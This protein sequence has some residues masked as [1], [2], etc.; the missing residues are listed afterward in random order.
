MKTIAFI[1]LIT[2]STTAY[3]AEMLTVKELQ[4]IVLKKNPKIM[5]MELEAAMLKQRIPQSTAIEDPKLKIGLNN[6]P[7]NNFS[8]KAEDMTSKEIGISQMFPLGGKLAVKE[9]IAQKEYI[10]SL[11]KIKKEKLEIF[12]ML[13]MNIY[14]LFYVR[15]SIK[16]VEEIK[17]QLQ[18]L[19]QSEVVSNKSGMG[20]LANVVK[21]NIEYT[22]I[23]EE[24]ISLKQQEKEILN[25][26]SYLAGREI[27]ITEVAISELDF[28]EFSIGDVKEKIENNNPNINILKIDEEING[29]EVILKQKEYYP[30]IEV[31]ISYMQ[32]DNGAMGSRPDMVSAMAQINIPLWY[33]KKNIPMIAEMQKKQ[34]MTKTLLIDKKN[35]L[36]YKAETVIGRLKQWE[37]L[38]K[39]YIEQMIPQTEIAFETLLSNYKTNRGEFMQ[40]IDTVRML[41]K[42][43][44][45]V[46]MIKKEYLSNVSELNTLMGTLTAPW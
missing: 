6:I 5:S 15:S 42:Y 31:G 16:I 14:D 13:N 44:K 40:I 39:L 25:R 43:K 1:I 26:I 11:E 41:L 17:E 10:K 20:T 19:V 34:E 3:G 28:K 2:I 24:L 27:D 30:D 37:N 12:N 38:Y 35:E 32:R 18:L 4:S 46:L 45:E 7:T 36:F 8:I 33:K 23:D 22:M 21:A 9:S 29:K